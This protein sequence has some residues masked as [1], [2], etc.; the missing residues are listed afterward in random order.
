MSSFTPGTSWKGRAGSSKQEGQGP[1][2]WPGL[3]QLGEPELK[4]R[5]AVAYNLHE[6]DRVHFSFS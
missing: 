6:K 4:S 3:R 5:E 1:G 2:G